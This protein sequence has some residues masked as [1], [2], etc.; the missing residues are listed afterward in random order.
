MTTWWADL[1]RD[2]AVALVA[3]GLIVPMVM[4]AGAILL[5]TLRTWRREL[6]RRLTPPPP[7][8]E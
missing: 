4:L 2:A 7:E 3:V 5:H 6:R 8:E 1:G